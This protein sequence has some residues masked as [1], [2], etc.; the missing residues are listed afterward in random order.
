MAL[1][2]TTT[3]LAA[4]AAR[5][6]DE[7]AER[8]PLRILLID[9]ENPYHDW[10]TTTPVLQAILRRGGGDRFIV[11]R[12]TIRTTGEGEAKRSDWRPTFA[13]YDA[14]L[15]NY[16][17]QVLPPEETQ[18]AFEK[19][20]ADGGGLVVVHAADNS[21]AQW[22]AYNE[23]CGLGGWYGRDERW[24][25]YVYYKDGKLVRDETPGP[26]GHHPPQHKYVVETR[27]AKHPIMLGLPSRW[28]HAQDELYD[29]L[30]GP[31]KNMTV[32]A[33]AHSD[34][35]I[36]GTGRDEPV[37]MTVEYGKGRVFHTVLG[38]ADYSLKCAGFV[39]TLLRGTEWAATGKATIPLPDN[40]PSEDQELAW[41]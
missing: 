10:E 35:A 1:I 38:H 13:G 25:P 27:D 19:F 29:R 28:L 17:S 40:M 37:L 30:R 6:E 33:T 21:F 16:N 12:V 3:G 2:A 14:V 36:G 15:S 41:E 20:V 24:G 9:G 4:S 8:S 18:R 22:P 23:M 39:A 34:P 26:G 5:A 7:P 32:L 31:A 11:D